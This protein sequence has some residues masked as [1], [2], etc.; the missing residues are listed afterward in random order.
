MCVYR[1][2]DPLLQALGTKI[3]AGTTIQGILEHLLPTYEMILHHWKCAK[4]K[5]NVVDQYIE[6][7]SA[8][9]VLRLPEKVLF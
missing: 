9:V 6:A 2:Q 3:F 4:K 1:G 7:I 8:A 5:M